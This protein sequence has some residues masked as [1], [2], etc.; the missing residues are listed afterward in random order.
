MLGV[1]TVAVAT[2]WQAPREEGLRPMPSDACELPRALDPRLRTDD[3]YV[4]AIRVQGGVASLEGE[5]KAFARVVMT[6]VSLR[7]L[8]AGAAGPRRQ[9]SAVLELNHAASCVAELRRILNEMVRSTPTPVLPAA[10]T[11]SWTSLAPSPRGHLRHPADRQRHRACARRRGRCRR[12]GWSFAGRPVR[13]PCVARSRRCAS[14][15]PSS[16]IDRQV[17]ALVASLR[18]VVDSAL[19][20]RRLELY[21]AAGSQLSATGT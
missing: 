4:R 13:R 6:G 3:L 12:F 10:G 19:E 7:Q 9:E 17:Q 20:R 21:M 14:K 11:W 1:G 18:K 2:P 15:V 8:A 5:T 16:Q